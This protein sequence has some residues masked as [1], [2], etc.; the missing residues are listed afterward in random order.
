MGPFACPR[1]PQEP[2]QNG[3]GTFLASEGL[4]VASQSQGFI[5]PGL[6]A[7]CPLASYQP[8]AEFRII[9]MN[10]KVIRIKNRVETG[11]S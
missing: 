3:W 6:P 10:K 5:R 11:R 2:K 1:R 9:R 4:T 7:V 8:L